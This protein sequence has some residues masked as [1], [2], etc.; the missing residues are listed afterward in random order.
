MADNARDQCR[1]VGWRKEE[2]EVVM[3]SDLSWVSM[4]SF[5]I[6]YT[7]KMT[8]RKARIPTE[9]ENLQE[10]ERSNVSIKETEMGALYVPLA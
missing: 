4:R 9:G 10:S 1:E 3:Y 8:S 6:T 7:P 2:V 5:E